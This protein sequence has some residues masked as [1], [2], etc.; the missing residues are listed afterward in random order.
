MLL[1]RLYTNFGCHCHCPSLPWHP[2]RSCI[3][4]TFTWRLRVFVDFRY[5][6]HAWDLCTSNFSL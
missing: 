3:C 2:V 4:A 5:Y 6:W 1:H